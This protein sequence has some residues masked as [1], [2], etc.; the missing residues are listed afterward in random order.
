[1][2]RR[3]NPD[4]IL[5]LGLGLPAGDWAALLADT[6]YALMVQARLR[7]N[8]TRALVGV[9]RK[10]SGG[11]QKVGLKIDMDE[12]VAGQSSMACGSCRWKR[13]QLGQHTDTGDVAGWWASTWGGG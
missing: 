2:L 6:T 7:C 9:R 8:G 4:Q 5:T 13:R 12:F 10:R 1:M 11:Q 3:S